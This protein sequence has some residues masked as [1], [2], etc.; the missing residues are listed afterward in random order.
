MRQLVHTMFI[1]NNRP[2]FQLWWNEN[3]VK[4]PKVSKYYETDCRC[5]WFWQKFFKIKHTYLSNRKQRV[6]I[7]GRYTT[8]SEILLE[9]TKGSILGPLLFNI[10]MCDL[11]YF[12][13]DFDIANYADNSTP[14]CTCTCVEFVV[15][16]PEQSSSLWMA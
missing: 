14:Y 5:V 11:L 4:H 12:L 10:F 13:E 2:L 3:L 15:N 6:K 9:I 16:N 7:N 8:W 1:S